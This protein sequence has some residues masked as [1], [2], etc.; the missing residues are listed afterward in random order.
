MLAAHAL[1]VGV[2]HCLLPALPLGQSLGW[3]VRAEAASG[4]LRL[5]E[6][7]QASSRLDLHGRVLYLVSPLLVVWPPFSEHWRV[8]RRCKP[9]VEAA[10]RSLSFKAVYPVTSV[11]FWSEGVGGL[12]GFANTPDRTDHSGPL[13]TNIGHRNLL[14]K[15]SA[16]G[17]LCSGFGDWSSCCHYYYGR[18]F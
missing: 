17:I 12:H 11:L 6:P 3:L 18:H 15:V 14:K 7:A 1:E 4:L 8:A 13:I 10:P 9:E 2:A 5:G 16:A